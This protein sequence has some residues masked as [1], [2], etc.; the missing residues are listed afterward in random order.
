MSIPLIVDAHEDLAWNML[1]WGRDYTRPVAETRRL[2]QGGPTVEI[3]GD[4]LIGWPEYQRGR[5]A[6]V[7]ATLFASPVRTKMGEWDT[8]HY[9]DAE[10]AHRQYWD[11]LQ[12]YRRLT[13]SNPERFRLV[14]DLQ[15]LDSHMAAWQEAGDRENPVGLILLMEGAD[16]IRTP[17]ELA[18]WHEAGLRLIGLS[19][20]GTRYAG[21]TREPGPLTEDGRRLL[22]AMAE[23]N[24]GLDLSHMDEAS[25][26][27]ALDLY[28]GPIVISHAN[29]SELLPGFETNRH[30]SDRVIRGVIEHD[31]VMGV[32][33][34]NA[35]LKTGWKR[36]N[37]SRREEVPLD[38]VAAHIDHICQLAGDA[39][40][41]GIGSDFDGGFGLQSVPPEIDSIA[42]LHKLIPLLIERGYSAPDASDILGGN[43][44][45]FLGS[46]LPAS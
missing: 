21:G 26:L 38:V 10:Q 25:A 29:C 16:G 6:L 34:L 19:W 5:V 46:N 2:E 42:D 22:K 18:E 12:L 39:R 45:R 1:M 24:F 37:G 13:D 31:G 44:L 4:C 3:N 15:E 11:Q 8:L 28:E 9:A 17:D 43:W 33:P 36:Q 32:V 40:H 23:F 20:A 41:A 35:F 30:V 7:F 27:E 14:R